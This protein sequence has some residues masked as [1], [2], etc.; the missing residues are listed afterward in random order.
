MSLLSI[1]CISVNRYVYICHHDAYRRL[2]ARYTNVV[3]VA[4]TWVVGV[5]LDVPSHAGWSAHAFDRKTQKCLWDRTL[6]HQ[7]TVFYVTVGMLLP[8]VIIVLCYWRIFVHIRR[9]KVRVLQARRGG[10]GGGGGGLGV[11]NTH[12]AIMKTIR[13]IK[14]IV[15]IFIVFCVCWA[16]YVVVLLSDEFDMFPLSVH[17]YASMI[18]HLHASI[19]FFIY[20]LANK[21]LR[22]SYH[23]FVVR[24]LFGLCCAAANGAAYSSGQTIA[25]RSCASGRS[26]DAVRA[27]R[28]RR[29][30]IV[31]N[32]TSVVMNE[33]PNQSHNEH[34]K[35]G[36]TDLKETI[37]ADCVQTIE[38]HQAYCDSDIDDDDEYA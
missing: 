35:G 8:L 11:G 25:T 21:G 29:K 30:T 12:A 9:A 32:P 37:C 20:G 16:P 23:D 1:G 24:R 38:Q 14:M 36:T 34:L 2:F 17:L 15:I 33:L 18:A 26:F 4:A 7:Y 3:I 5:A 27:S 10:N 22:A 28:T 6:S 19:N 31:Q 13:Q